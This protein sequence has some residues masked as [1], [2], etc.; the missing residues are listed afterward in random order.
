MAFTPSETPSLLRD[1]CFQYLINHLEKIPVEFLALLPTAIRRT[2]AVHLPV[3][4]I[5]QLEQTRFAS[6]LDMPGVWKEVCETWHLLSRYPKLAEMFKSEHEA[7]EFVMVV[8]AYEA[9]H[10]QEEKR[11]NVQFEGVYYNLLLNKP[12]NFR[13]KPPCIPGPLVFFSPS[14]IEEPF[15]VPH[16]AV[17]SRFL[18]IQKEFD[19]S[20]LKLLSTRY[21]ICLERLYVD[22]S[23][24]VG[25]MDVVDVIFP[26][27]KQVSISCMDFGN[28]QSTCL[29]H[30]LLSGCSQCLHTLTLDDCPEDKIQEIV[31]TVV[32]GFT[33]SP[34]NFQFL[35]HFRVTISLYR[36]SEKRNYGW[37]RMSLTNEIERSFKRALTT[38]SKFI[39][40]HTSLQTCSLRRWQDINGDRRYIYSFI[41][42]MLEQPQFLCLTLTESTLSLQG[43]QH[44]V[45]TFLNIPCSGPQMLKLECV[46][47]HVNGIDHT[48]PSIRDSSF[49]LYKSLVLDC[50]IISHSFT[51]NTGV[52][53]SLKKW[54]LTIWKLRQRSLTITSDYLQ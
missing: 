45:H 35:R 12:H 19:G 20:F 54:L 26:Q 29:V 18:T 13:A 10:H 11:Q 28:Y 25:I 24:C 2:L 46:Q 33:N 43:I 7:K 4:D 34:A 44:V 49:L 31:T 42:S 14:C 22:C 51:N 23:S 1:L 40:T 27:L 16:C 50:R 48:V 8:V 21:H 5:L 47:V 36:A 32:S 53:S 39:Q 15:K 38:L 41:L 52:Q 37:N 3:A 30:S 17:P 6:G 9:F